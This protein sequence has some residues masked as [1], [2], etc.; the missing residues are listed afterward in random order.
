MK[1]KATMNTRRDATRRAQVTMA[2][3]AVALAGVISVGA[4]APALAEDEAPDQAQQP[5]V[6]LDDATTDEGSWD[7]T[8]QEDGFAVDANVYAPEVFADQN[9]LGS[10]DA[11]FG[12]DWWWRRMSPW[13]ALQSAEDYLG[14]YGFDD[15]DYQTGRFRGTPAYRI[16]IE[17]NDGWRPW[18][19]RWYGTMRYVVFVNYFTGNVL[20]AYVDYA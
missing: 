1:T 18:G 13:D 3:V 20:A 10:P 5:E 12:T 19:R 2:V 9:G 6:A 17:V 14:I 16:E 8:A 4:A 11:A 15:W 7:S